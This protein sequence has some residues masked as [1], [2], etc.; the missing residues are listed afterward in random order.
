MEEIPRCSKGSSKADPEGYFFF[1]LTG[2]DLKECFGVTG[3]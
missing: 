1:L 3:G 2:K